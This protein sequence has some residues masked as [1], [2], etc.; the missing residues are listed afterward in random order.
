LK[1]I[2][3]NPPGGYYASRWEETA[4]PS[5]GLGYLA[6][7]L[8]QAGVS[9]EILD[10][11][12]LR[13]NLGDLRRHL[14]DSRPDIVGVTMTTEN[15]FE[16]FGAVR[17]A[18]A[19]LPKAMVIAGG[20]H[21][22]A[23]AEDTLSH[24]PELDIV[25]RG[26]GEETLLDLAQGV[27][28]P[29]RIPGISHRE[30]GKIVHNPDRPYIKD[31]DR[32]PFPARNLMPMEK[33]GYLADVPGEGK[34]PA[35]NIM[36]SRGCPFNCSFC[37][38]PKMWGRRYRARS[39]ENVMEEID[40]LVNRWGARALWVFDDTFTI[41]RKRTLA[42]C[43]EIAG[44]FP[45]LRWFCEIRVDTVDLELL[46]A[47]KRAGCFCVAFGVES[48]SQRVI[49]ESVGKQIRLEQ[50]RQTMDWCRRLD[51]MYNPFII[52]SHPGETEEDA[53]KTMEL[54]RECKADGASVS[55]AIMHIYPGT[56]IESIAYEKGILPRD[57]SW[58]S[59]S[60]ARR[61]PML[62]AAQG[63]V[64]VFL[65]QLSWEFLSR[66]LFEWAEMQ[67][68]SVWRRI[69]KALAG[70]RS[71]SDVKRYWTM[72]RTYIAGARS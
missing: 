71:L 66:C 59:R 24:I 43:D 26:E 33:Y 47:M 8:Q 39:T 4:L 7:Y 19:A 13:W 65:D 31:L 18:R 16:G 49:D 69:P 5:L 51:L 54:V 38:S 42:I 14:K 41:D 50:V 12:A 36:A 61:A 23:A 34:L 25:V 64:P 28:S 44:K 20:P 21:V 3:I 27:E 52:L 10:A 11:H 60:D 62:P 57:F 29:G 53:R 63:K 68:Y 17:A 22:S 6:S 45:F 35:Q 30:D 70:T 67:K 72:F 46:A 2:L 15:R 9:C 58:A 55:M 40:E 32:L 56:R 37:A 48:G 1:V